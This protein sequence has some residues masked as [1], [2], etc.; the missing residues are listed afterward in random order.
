MTKLIL[1][2]ALMPALLLC[3]PS[4]N[5]T[6]NNGNTWNSNDLLAEGKTIVVNFFSPSMTCWPSSNAT[7]NVAETYHEM[8]Q[9]NEDKLFFLQVAQWGY[10]WVVEDFVEEFGDT[11][12][13]YI[14]GYSFPSNYESTT[15]E[16]SGI[17][18]CLTYDW[19]FCCYW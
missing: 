7:E 17:G 8:Y 6:D 11:N 3:Q 12:I 19:C 5:V 4:F 15:E 18:Q 16:C 10:S 9:C 2:I 13:P 14:E 1:F